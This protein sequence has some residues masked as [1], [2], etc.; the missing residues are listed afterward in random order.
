MR[1]T[2]KFFSFQGQYYSYIAH[3]PSLKIIDELIF[4]SSNNREAINSDSVAFEGIEDS[5][6]FCNVSYRYPNSDEDA[7]SNVSF[8]INPR[9]FI[10]I[11]GPSGA[12]KSTILDLC[13]GLIKPTEGEI[14]VDGSDLYGLNINSYRKKLGFVSQESI[15][16]MDL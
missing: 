15:F 5:I 1:I 10:A 16:L 7:V 8:K 2:P 11:V 13:I 14:L 12:G 9:N 3:K 6:E 4:S